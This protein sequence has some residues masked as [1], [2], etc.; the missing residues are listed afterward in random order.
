MTKAT[1]FV[2]NYFSYL[3]PLEA[4]RQAGRR[5]W[6]LYLIN[7]TAVNWTDWSTNQWIWY[8]RRD[9]WKVGVEYSLA[10]RVNWRKITMEWMAGEITLRL[11]WQLCEG[12]MDGWMRRK[13]QNCMKIILLHRTKQAEVKEIEMKIYLL[14]CFGFLSFIPSPVL[15]LIHPLIN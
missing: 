14:I 13:D 6:T 15:P 8:L 11:Q 9:G 3:W 12:R 7:G 4:G 2:L 5:L 1:I 10:Q